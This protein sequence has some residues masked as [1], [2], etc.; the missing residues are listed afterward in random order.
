MSIQSMVVTRIPEAAQFPI[1]AGNGLMGRVARGTSR[2]YPALLGI[3][4]GIS[5]R[6][7]VDSRDFCQFVSAMSIA[8]KNGAILAGEKEPWCGLRDGLVQG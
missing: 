3:S 1:R 6:G 8:A 2:R 4:Y 5:V 7:P